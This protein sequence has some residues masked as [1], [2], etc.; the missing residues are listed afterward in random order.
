MIIYQQKLYEKIFTT[1]V[2]NTV[3]PFIWNFWKQK[4]ERLKANIS[5]TIE[6]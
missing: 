4:T 5:Q 6:D 3:M 1:N 2:G